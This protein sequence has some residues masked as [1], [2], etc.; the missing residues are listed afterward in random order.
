MT[1]QYFVVFMDFL[2]PV[3]DGISATAMFRE[4]EATQPG[5]KHQ[6][7]MGMSANA[8]ASDV[9]ASKDAGIDFFLPK[10]VKV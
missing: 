4:W 1:E 9:Q 3:L 10:P 5:R 6:P 7:I 8:E 2:M